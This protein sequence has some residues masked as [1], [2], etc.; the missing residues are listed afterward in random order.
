MVELSYC[1]ALVRRYDHDRFLTTLFAPRDRREALLALYAFNFEIARTRESVSEPMLG[2][3]RLQ[4]WREALEE[5][6]G[7]RPRRHAVVAALAEAL[8]DAPVPASALVPLVDARARDLDPEPFA[9]LD[10]FEAY[11]AATAGNLVGLALRL[12][13]TEAP[14]HLSAGRQVGAAWGM[15]GLLR[16]VPFHAARRLVFLPADAMAAHGITPG[17]LAERRG[18]GA[19]SP[20][21]AM[22][23]DAA[24]QRLDHGVRGLAGLPPGARPAVLVAP[25]ARLELKRLRRHGDDPFAVEPDGSP[26]RRIG[27]LAWSAWRGRL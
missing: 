4:W 18:G 19:L 10:E 8:R 15:A 5:I 25:L 12:L 6:D 26:L 7:G 3:I 11:A 23:A 22:V 24:R 27:A 1:A 14:G 16:A 13:G 20:V 21:V 17:D 9:T 2:E